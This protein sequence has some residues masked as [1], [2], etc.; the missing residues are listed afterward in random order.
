MKLEWLGVDVYIYPLSRVWRARMKGNGNR[1]DWEQL[2]GESDEAYAC[3]LWYCSLPP[4]ERSLEELW[5]TL[6]LTERKRFEEAFQREQEE[7]GKK[8]GRG[9]KA[10]GKRT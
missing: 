6:P 1:A 4:E 8:A 7:E 9:K 10:T 3:F 5:R 2:P